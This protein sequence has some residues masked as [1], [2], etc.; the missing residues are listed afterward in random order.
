MSAPVLLLLVLTSGLAPEATPAVPSPEVADAPTVSAEAIPAPEIAAPEAA[1]DPVE[2]AD[3]DTTDTAPPQGPALVVVLPPA[4]IPPEHGPFFA[5]EPASD[6]AFVNGLRPDD[7]PRFS[8][9]RGA[10]CFVDDSKCRASLVLTADI[11]VGVN[12]VGGNRLPDLP[13]AHYNFRGG[14]VFKPLMRRGGWHPW[15]VGL[16]GSWSRGTGPP[17]TETTLRAPHTDAWRILIVNQLWMS[18]RRNGFH[19]DLDAG[20]VRSPVIGS[21]NPYF[22]TSAGLSANWGGWGGIFMHG[23]FL[24]KDSRIVFGFRGHGMAVAP[25]IGLVLLGLLAGGAL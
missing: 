6:T 25:V 14:I 22:G 2:V 19:L 21:V 1:S 5:G 8:V 23:D 4:K 13:Y 11:G 18:K 7:P 20:L 10:F 17:E 15:G 12:L 3:T 24:D 9:G 16:V